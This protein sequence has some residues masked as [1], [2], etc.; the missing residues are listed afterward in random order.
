MLFATAAAAEHSPECSVPA[1][2]GY[3]VRK[4]TAGPAVPSQEDQR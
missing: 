1:R 4:L 3:H 2:R